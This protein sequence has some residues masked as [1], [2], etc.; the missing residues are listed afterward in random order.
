ML[1]IYKEGWGSTSRKMLD[2]VCQLKSRG[3]ISL[4]KYILKRQHSCSSKLLLRM[5]IKPFACKS[6]LVS[7]NKLKSYCKAACTQNTH[8]SFIYWG[9]FNQIYNLNFYFACKQMVQNKRI[10]RFQY[11]DHDESR[12][13]EGQ[14]QFNMYSTNI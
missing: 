7:D 11:F 14:C 9:N 10:W 1:D 2:I 8:F 13:S 5:R 3:N 4:L 12:S 6:V